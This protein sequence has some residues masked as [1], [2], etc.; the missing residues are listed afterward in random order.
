ML[1]Y[2]DAYAGGEAAVVTIFCDDNKKY[3]SSALVQSEPL[4]VLT[5]LFT[6]L[7]SL[8]LYW[9]T[10]QIM[11]QKSEPLKVL[12]LLLSFLLYWYNS[13]NT[14]AEKRALD[15]AI[16]QF[17]CFTSTPRQILTQKS[18]RKGGLSFAETSSLS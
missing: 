2:A 18:E 3:L 12:T 13:T 7:L 4:K 5:L 10:V 16:P 6:L 17:T 1:T 15:G 8:Q 11:T 9:Y 14:D